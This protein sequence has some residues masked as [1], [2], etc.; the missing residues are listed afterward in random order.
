LKGLEIRQRYVIRVRGALN[1]KL[2]NGRA[3]RHNFVKNQVILG[4]GKKSGS[5]G[6]TGSLE[7][8][9]VSAVTET[10]GRQGVTWEGNKNFGPSKI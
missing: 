1:T 6:R 9:S 5:D 8:V 3:K 7:G 2:G 4:R 10:Q